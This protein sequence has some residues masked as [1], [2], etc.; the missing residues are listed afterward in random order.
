MLD[1]IWLVGMYIVGQGVYDNGW[2]RLC[3]DFNTYKNAPRDGGG[4]ERPA[5]AKGAAGGHG[6]YIDRIRG[7]KGKEEKYGRADV[8]MN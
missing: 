8:W 1:W 4:G 7:R 3:D 5:A 2:G 6:V